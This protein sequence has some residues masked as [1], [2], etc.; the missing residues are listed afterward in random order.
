MVAV[1][2]N[3]K[4][5]WASGDFEIDVQKLSTPHTA[6]WQLRGP[7]ADPAIGDGKLTILNGKMISV[8]NQA[9]PL[10]AEAV[11]YGKGTQYQNY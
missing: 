7:C 10:S 5:T 1:F 4:D 11:L 9:L 6:R 3:H 2:H 8:S